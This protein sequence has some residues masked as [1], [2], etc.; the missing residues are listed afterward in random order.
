MEITQPSK[1]QRKRDMAALQ[2]IGARLV[3]LNAGQLAEIGLP[4]TLHE[5]VV[6]AQRIR[7]FEGRRRQLQYIGKLMRA[8]DPAPIVACL[9]RWRGN[10]RAHTALQQL[11]ESWRERL[12]GEEDAFASF[13]AGYPGADLQPL[14]SLIAGVRRDQAAGRAPKQYREL[15]RAIREIVGGKDD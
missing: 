10:A 5:A 11:A 2:K 6:E 12:L 13:A 7:D 14:R 3:E 15:F 8:V 4:E 1:S 9:E